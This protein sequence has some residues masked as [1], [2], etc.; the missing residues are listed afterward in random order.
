[1]DSI[2]ASMRDD[3]DDYQKNYASPARGL[4]A[5]LEAAT[6]QAELLWVQRKEKEKY[7]RPSGCAI[8]FGGKVDS[9]CHNCHQTGHF[10]REC[11]LKM[12]DSN[13]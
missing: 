12:K 9:M 2:F 10:G 6:I 5:F 3:D 4:T 11:P 1:M 8:N 13:Y 7:A